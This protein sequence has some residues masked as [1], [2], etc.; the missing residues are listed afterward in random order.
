MSTSERHP[1]THAIA[2]RYLDDGFAAGL[3]GDLEAAGLLIQPGW[4][5]IEFEDDATA[6][7]REQLAAL[8]AEVE[9]QRT[10]SHSCLGSPP[11]SWRACSGPQWTAFA[12]RSLRPLYGGGT[13]QGQWGREGGRQPTTRDSDTRAD[14]VTGH[15]PD[16]GTCDGVLTRADEE[17]G[18]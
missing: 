5:R 15:R 7:D 6:R 12:A 1:Q 4:I 8:R 2:R 17:D 16:T 10:S 3:L 14:R 11:A 9:W 13:V 18:H